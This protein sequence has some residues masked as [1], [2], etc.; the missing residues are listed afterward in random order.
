MAITTYS[1]LQTAL[2]DYMGDDAYTGARAQT[3]IALAEGQLNRVLKSVRSSASLTGTLD[4]A[5]IDVSSYNVISPVALYLTTYEE[6]DEIVFRAQGTMPF[7]DGSGYPSGY[8]LIADND[9]IRF[10][11]PLQQAYTFRF[12][13]IGRFA[14]SETVTTNQLLTDH[15]DVYFTAALF[16]GAVKNQDAELAANYKALLEGYLAEARNYLSQSR[17][18][19]LQPDR[20][21]LAMS[22]GNSAY[23]I[24][25][26]V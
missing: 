22:G 18:G 7:N 3:D 26:D 23:N 12:E 8:T 15:P 10:D 17:R 4:A 2:I 24:E 9:T 21:L 5:T 20:S 6:D 11:C 19:L 16:W 1:E 25:T 13:Y 14:L